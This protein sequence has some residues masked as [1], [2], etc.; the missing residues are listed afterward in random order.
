MI[1]KNEYVCLLQI[2]VTAYRMRSKDFTSFSSFFIRETA[3]K[4]KI[5]ANTGKIIPS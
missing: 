2:N 1:S 3:S 4:L 5:S